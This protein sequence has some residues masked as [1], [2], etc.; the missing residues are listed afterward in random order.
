M[1]ALSSRYWIA[2][3]VHGLYQSLIRVYLVTTSLFIRGGIHARFLTE[4]GELFQSSIY[5]VRKSLR[6][7]QLCRNA[8]GLS[9]CIARPM[10]QCAVYQHRRARQHLGTR[11]ACDPF[12]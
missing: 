5:V 7:E 2:G 1:V 3:S 8:G 11:K 12:F 10:S 6:T 9:D 4:P